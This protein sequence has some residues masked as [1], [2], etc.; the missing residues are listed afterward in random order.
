MRGDDMRRDRN[1]L[2]LL[3]RC[4]DNEIKRLSRYIYESV[5]LEEQYP[6]LAEVFIQLA[7]DEV[8]TLRSLEMLAGAYG[9]K[10]NSGDSTLAERIEKYAR[11]VREDIADYEELL[12]TWQVSEQLQLLFRQLDAKRSALEQFEKI[13]ES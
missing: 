11:N 7:F 3:A 10:E 1:T 9:G 5:I 12:N 4:Y 2:T 13:L 8:E 6:Q